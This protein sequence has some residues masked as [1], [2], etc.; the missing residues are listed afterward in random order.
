MPEKVTVASIA[1]L[2]FSFGCLIT[3]RRTWILIGL[4]QAFRLGRPAQNAGAVKAVSIQ[5]MDMITWMAVAVHQRS[6][7]LGF[8]LFVGLAIV[9]VKVTLGDCITRVVAAIYLRLRYC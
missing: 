7:T 3:N 1:I 8:V 4:D 6:G 5:G 9:P 2:F